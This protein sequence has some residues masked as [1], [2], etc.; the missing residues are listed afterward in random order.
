MRRTF[1]E[2]VT[3][4]A[5]AAGCECRA[6]EGACQAA[7][8]VEGLEFQLGLIEASG[9]LVIQTGVGLLPAADREPFLLDLLKANSLFAETSGLTLGVDLDMELVTL[10][11]AWEMEHLDGNRFANLMA[12]VGAEAVRWM[13]RLDRWRPEALDDVAQV[14]AEGM[15]ILRV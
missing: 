8:Q 6:A 5:Q 12:N 4:F 10:Q 1:H 9:M 14:G 11:V 15:A 13:E 7:L 3:G 2:L